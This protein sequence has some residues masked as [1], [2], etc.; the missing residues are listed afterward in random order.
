MNQKQ[1]LGYMVL[2][3]GILALGIIIGQ[4]VTPDIEAQSNGV[5]EKIQCRELEVVDKD[6]L[7]GVRLAAA[8]NGT[9]GVSV[10]GK[11]GVAAANIISSDKGNMININN[12]KELGIVLYSGIFQNGD[13]G[14]FVEVYNPQR[15]KT[16]VWLRCD[17]SGNALFLKGQAGEESMGLLAVEK[18]EPFILIE[19]RAGKTIWST[20]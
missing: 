14:N 9:N 3:A 7:V 8:D 20:P 19:D 13:T 2:G 1:K 15:K 10:F 16:G 11:Q 5:F 18:G 12:S 17:E 6:G 4:W